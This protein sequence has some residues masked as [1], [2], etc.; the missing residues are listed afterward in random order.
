MGNT[1][2]NRSN[3]IPGILLGILFLSIPIIVKA[4]RL[5]L[6]IGSTHQS[7]LAYANLSKSFWGER[8]NSLSFPLFEDGTR[9]EFSASSIKYKYDA[10][11]IRIGYALPYSGQMFSNTSLFI[12]HTSINFPA[13]IGPFTERGKMKA[14]AL[15]IELDRSLIDF[16]DVST[17][18]IGANYR[19]LSASYQ[20][21][22]LDIKDNTHEAYAYLNGVWS[23]SN[24]HL[25]ARI[26]NTGFLEIFLKINVS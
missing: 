17:L 16:T 7:N 24:F 18:K 21:N 6:S 8:E 14:T 1:H 25:N 11:P 22:L 26:Y 5:T 12:E 20:S 9:S 3:I 23:F 13:G 15:G 2:L 4:D 19:Y 10:P